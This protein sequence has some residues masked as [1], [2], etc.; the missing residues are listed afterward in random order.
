MMEVVV[1][2]LV[3]EISSCNVKW[4]ELPGVGRSGRNHGPIPSGWRPRNV[5]FTTAPSRTCEALLL[6]L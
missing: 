6:L 5:F 2:D 1:H 4:L 3:N